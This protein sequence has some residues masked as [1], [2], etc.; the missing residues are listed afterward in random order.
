MRTILAGTTTFLFLAALPVL[1]TKTAPS[2]PPPPD[3]PSLCD[4]IPGNLVANCG[5]ETGD[6][7]DWTLSGNGSFTGVTGGIYAHTGNF[8][9]FLGPVG[10]DGYLTQNVATTSGNAYTL[11]FWLLNEGGTP[12][13]FDVSLN[14]GATEVFLLTDAPAQPYTEYTIP[15]VATGATALQFSFQQNPAYWGLDD[16]SITPA[17]STV[18]EPTSVVLLLSLLGI[19]GFGL[20]RHIRHRLAN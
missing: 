10:S 11:Q 14:G 18:P 9:A 13:N 15:F 4:S 3:P 6:F 17:V 7:T 1:A 19:A 16:I 20:R 2:G 8:G 5:F 12:N